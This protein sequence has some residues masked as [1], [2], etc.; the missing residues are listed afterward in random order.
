[1]TVNTKLIWHGELLLFVYVSRRC[2]DISLIEKIYN[3]IS[4]KTIDH[5]TTEAFS[6]AILSRNSF[7]ILFFNFLYKFY[8]L[9]RVYVS[10]H[11]CKFENIFVLS[12]I[13]WWRTRRPSVTRESRRARGRRRGRRRK[14][15]KAHIWCWSSSGTFGGSHRRLGS[16]PSPSG[17]TR[18]CGMQIVSSRVERELFSTSDLGCTEMHSGIQTCWVFL[19]VFGTCVS[20]RKKGKKDERR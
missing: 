16:G 19:C 12:G 1:M 3:S 15:W 2:S 5:R 7:K 10:T 18:R 14:T 17:R 20:S 9:V 13:F 11:M 6:T 8:I 4:A